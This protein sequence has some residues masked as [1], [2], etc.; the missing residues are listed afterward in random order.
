MDSSSVPEGRRMTTCAGKHAHKQGA[1]SQRRFV[2]ENEQQVMGLRRRCAER[3]APLDERG[4]RVMQWAEW[5]AT[6]LGLKVMPGFIDERRGKK[7]RTC[8]PW[9]LVSS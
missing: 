8:G 4:R 9:A 3:S 5:Y 1:Q 6:K 2:P 7:K